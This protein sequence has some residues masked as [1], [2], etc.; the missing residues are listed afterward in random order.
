VIFGFLGDKNRKDLGRQSGAGVST[1]LSQD[2]LLSLFV[3][4]N[5]KTRVATFT[6]GEKL[7]NLSTVEAPALASKKGKKASRRLTKAP[8]RHSHNFLRST[9]AIKRK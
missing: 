6:E 8:A 4:C 1:C 7:P 3:V 2:N 9:E 5:T